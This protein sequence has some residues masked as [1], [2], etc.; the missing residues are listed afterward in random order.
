MGV[1][2]FGPEGR[3]ASYIPWPTFLC[4]CPVAFVNLFMLISCSICGPWGAPYHCVG[5]TYGTIGGCIFVTPSRFV[6]QHTKKAGEG[7]VYSFVPAWNGIPNTRSVWPRA[8]GGF[9]FEEGEA[10]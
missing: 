7:I 6:S 3:V 9:S 10:V 5:T 2:V 4:L 8:E 1:D